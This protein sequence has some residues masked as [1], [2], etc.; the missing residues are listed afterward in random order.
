MAGSGEASTAKDSVSSF[1]TS[2]SLIFWY[3][4]GYVL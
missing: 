1:F 2:S 3:V 4:V